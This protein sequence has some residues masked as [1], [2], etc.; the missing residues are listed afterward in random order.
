MVGHCEWLFFRVSRLRRHSSQKSSSPSR[1]R[2]TPAPPAYCSSSQPCWLWLSWGCGKVAWGCFCPNLNGDVETLEVV[3]L[4]SGGKLLVHLSLPWCRRFDVGRR[5]PMH[6]EL[7]EPHLLT[8]GWWWPG[9]VIVAS[10]PRREQMYF[11]VFCIFVL[12]RQ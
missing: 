11:F 9:Q 4:D 10:W 1:W 8:S 7:D 6:H 2:K 12:S 5:V 3:S